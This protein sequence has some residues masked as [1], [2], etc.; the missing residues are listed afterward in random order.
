[1]CVCGGGK[2]KRFVLQDSFNRDWFEDAHDVELYACYNLHPMKSL[3]KFMDLHV[4]P[5]GN[6]QRRCKA[7]SLC[8]R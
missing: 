2:E 1:M 5:V 6:A 4:F 8:V 3:E 7:L